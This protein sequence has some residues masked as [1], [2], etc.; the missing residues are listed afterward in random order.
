MKTMPA[1]HECLIL[2]YGITPWDKFSNDAFD[3][4]TSSI[5][6]I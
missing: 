5:S 2:F 3:N 4:L 6:E 1:Y